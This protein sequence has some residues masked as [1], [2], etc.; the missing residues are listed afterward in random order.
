MGTKKSL[1]NFLLLTLEKSIDGYIR[2]DH[3]VNKPHLYAHYGWWDRPLKKSALALALKRLRE[4]GLVELI[5]DRELIVRLTDNGRDKALWTKMRLNDEKWDG[6]WRLVIWDIPE[7]RRVA[8]DLLRHK[9][10]WLGFR[11]LQKSVWITKKN[12]TQ[13]LRDFI[14]KMGIRDWVVVIESDNVDF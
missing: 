4:N 8:R 14:K 6:K 12:C 2:F 10:K 3:F 1:T 9:L 13:V 7:K 5:D 11:K